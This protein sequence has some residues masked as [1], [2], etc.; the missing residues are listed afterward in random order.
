MPWCRVKRWVCKTFTSYQTFCT[1]VICLCVGRLLAIVHPASTHKW[2]ELEHKGRIGAV[3]FWDSHQTCL[4]PLMFVECPPIPNKQGRYHQY[5]SINHSCLEIGLK[6]I[7]CT[8]TFP[9]HELQLCTLTCMPSSSTSI[10]SAS[11]IDHVLYQMV[12]S[13][14][15]RAERNNEIDAAPFN[16]FL[17][18]AAALLSLN[19]AYNHY[20]YPWHYQILLHNLG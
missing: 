7:D 2:C 20:R 14:I 6:I 15:N 17:A 1:K 10:T 8:S 5:V 9:L 18:G 11:D 12:H 19:C 4:T 3:C 13:T 16:F